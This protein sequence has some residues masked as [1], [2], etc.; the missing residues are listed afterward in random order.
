MYPSPNKGTGV[1]NNYTATRPTY[2]MYNQYIGRVDQSFSKNTRIYAIATLQT[3]GLTDGGNEI[4]NA[5]S[6]AINTPDTDY[7]VILDFT[8]VFSSSMVLDLKASYGHYIEVSTTGTALQDNFLASDLGF[9]MPYVGS[10]SHQNIAPALTIAGETA[11]F[12][13]TQS[14][15]ANADADFSGSVTQLIGRHNLHYGGEFMDIQS[16]TKGIVGTPN[17]AFSFDSTFTQQNPLTAKTGQGN[18]IADL[19]LGYPS[20]G[21]VAWDANGFTVR[22]YY[23]LFLQDDFKVL[24]NLMLN[25]GLRWDVDLSPSER[26]NRMNA[27]FCL[28]CTNPYASQVNYAAAPGLTNPLQGGLLF[29]GVNGVSSAPYQVF[30]NDWQP[31]IGISWAVH[32]DTVIRAGYGV[33]DTVPSTASGSSGF[34]QSTSFVSSLPGTLTPGIPSGY[35]NAGT[36]FPTGAI[37]PTGAAAGLETN[38]GNGINYTNTN[39]RIRMTQHWS[40]GIQQKMPGALLLD[41]EY[42]GTN[43]HHIPVSTSLGVISTA[44]QQVCLAGGAVCN[45]PVANPFYGV[46]A[47]N[48]LLGASSTIPEWELMRAYPLFDGV[49]ENSVSSGGSHYNSLNVRVE[50]RLKSLDFV[51]N[52]AWSNWVTIDSYLNNGSFRDP[53]LWKGLDPSDQKNY[54]DANVVYPL[55]STSKTGVIGA[56]ANGWLLDSTVIWGTGTPLALPSATFNCASYAP[57]GGQTRAH[58]FNNDESCWTPLVPWQP[59]TTPNWIGSLRNPG[60]LLWN[61]AFHKQFTL[62]REGMF[63]QFR[64]EA[65]N[66]ANHPTWGAPSTA[67]GTPAKFSPTTSWTGFGTLPT[68]SGRSQRVVITS[69]TIVF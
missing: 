51:F 39:K 16:A 69:L 46:L 56:L 13:N 62:P 5:A 33:Y 19:L 40:F 66:G 68:T 54:L 18:E 20:T 57:Q 12:G 14:G 34:S 49:T 45:T 52:Y 8:H 22:H 42:M 41:M 55:P 48:T 11:L 60:M 28:T 27:G 1:T 10:T 47:S 23:G 26:H 2:Y 21:S 63:A 30:W 3:N 36:P 50:R 58:W 59:Q 32:P 29:A 38:A 25:L 61:P 17:G 15:G 6:T 65:L 64:M 7:N 35:F 44:Q 53:N 67:I 37:T 43:A 4:N 9:N 24:P 31:R